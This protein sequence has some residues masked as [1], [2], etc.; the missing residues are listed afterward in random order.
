MQFIPV[1]SAPTLSV[2]YDSHWDCLFLSLHGQLELAALREITLE[3]HALPATKI[4]PARCLVLDNI[5]LTTTEAINWLIDR[6][7]P[8]FHQGGVQ[9][10]TW[11]CKPTLRSHYLAEQVAKRVPQLMLTVFTDLEHATTWLQR[12]K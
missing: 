11:V 10:W 1:F 8:S 7:L 2:D 6:L 5:S 4:Y 12:D 9:Y 3:G